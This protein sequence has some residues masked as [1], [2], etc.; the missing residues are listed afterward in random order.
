MGIIRIGGFGIEIRALFIKDVFSG[1]YIRG[2]QK[3]IK[4]VNG[5]M[6]L[7][8]S[9][10]KYSIQNT[11]DGNTGSLVRNKQRQVERMPPTQS[12]SSYR[13]AVTLSPFSLIKEPSAAR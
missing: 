4:K 6:P 3:V 8:F 11:R 9:F 13:F 10:K 12:S 7:I 5:K 1:D 2:E